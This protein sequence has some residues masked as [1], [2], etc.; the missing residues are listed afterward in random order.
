MKKGGGG[1]GRDEFEMEKGG[2]GE[3]GGVEAF[4]LERGERSGGYLERKKGRAERAGKERVCVWGKQLGLGA[5]LHAMWCAETSRFE[6]GSP[7]VPKTLRKS[8]G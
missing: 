3:S 8:L 5:T 7:T 6:G 2:G 4:G 1:G